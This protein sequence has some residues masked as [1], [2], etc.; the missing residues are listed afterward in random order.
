[1][2]Y[3]GHKNDKYKNTLQILKEEEWF[4]D[5]L[6]EHPMACSCCGK[7]NFG[8]IRFK[9]AICASS[10]VCESCF[11]KV[12]AAPGDMREG[13]EAKGC[14]VDTHVYLAIFYNNVF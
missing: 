7:K 5:D 14:A 1:L 2:Y 9:C 6:K 3:V 13:L 12:R 8:G 11:E 4:E 10:N